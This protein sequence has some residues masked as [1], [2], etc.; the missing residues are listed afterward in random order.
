MMMPWPIYKARAV[1]TPASLSSLWE[2]LL[3][4]GGRLELLDYYAAA[5]T[6]STDIREYR[7]QRADFRAT[8]MRAIDTAPQIR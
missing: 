1:A 3:S 6:S 2:L 5:A 8:L 4:L 7:R